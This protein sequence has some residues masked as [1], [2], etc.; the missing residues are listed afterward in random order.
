M[1][2]RRENEPVPS[3][4]KDFETLTLRKI[5]DAYGVILD[6]DLVDRLGLKE[7]DPL[8]IVRTPHGIALTPF[9]PEFAEA[10]EAGR[11]Y[12]RRHRNAMGA[13]AK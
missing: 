4:P 2:N 12:M 1:R 7:G 8:F 10:V 13:L 5:A 11:D 9:D 3:K 6:R